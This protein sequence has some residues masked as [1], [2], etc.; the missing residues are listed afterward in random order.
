[1][2][3]RSQPGGQGGRGAIAAF[4]GDTTADELAIDLA[5]DVR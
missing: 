5:G 1:M 2:H 4:G 3:N